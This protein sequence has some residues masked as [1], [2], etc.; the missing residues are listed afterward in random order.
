MSNRYFFDK[1][2]W[3]RR[4]VKYGIILLLSF[5]PIV[6]FN[7]YCSDYIGKD[8]LV[9]LIDC[10]LILGFVVIGNVIMEKIY[11]KKDAKLERLRKERD[12]AEAR[13]KQI[14]EESYKKKRSNKKQNKQSTS[15]ENIDKESTSEKDSTLEQVVDNNVDLPQK[16]NISEPSVRNTKVSQTK[17]ST[18]APT[19]AKTSNKKQSKK[20]TINKGDSDGA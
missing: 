13:K 5:F 14:L 12:E 3:K 17:K 1:R 2:D 6:I 18:K 10:L 7:I 16:D 4:T 11:A 20:I 8:W 9:I 15:G 19:L